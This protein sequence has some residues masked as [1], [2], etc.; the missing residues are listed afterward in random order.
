M[1]FRI[2]VRIKLNVRLQ[3]FLSVSA[4]C[5]RVFPL[6]DMVSHCVLVYI[7]WDLTQKKKNMCIYFYRNVKIADL[8]VF[9]FSPCKNYSLS[10]FICFLVWSISK[11]SDQTQAA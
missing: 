5:V 8:C 4:I 10:L 2:H 9:F 3:F 7:T 1:T 11:P 6:N